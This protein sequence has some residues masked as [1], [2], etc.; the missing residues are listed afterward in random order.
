MPNCV[1]ASDVD[2]WPLARRAAQ[3]VVLPSLDFNVTALSQLIRGGVGGVLFLG[4][5]A[6]PSDLRARISM[7][8][9]GLSRE[10]VPLVMADVEGG[11]VQR[12]QPV[13][14]PF[15]W[16]RDLASSRSGADVEHLAETVGAQMK[17]AGVTVDLGPVVDLDDRPGPSTTNPDGRRSF[18][19]SPAVASGDSIAFMQ[20]LRTA[21]VT[22]VLKHFPGLGGSTHNTDFGPAATLPYAA[23]RASGLQPFINAIRAGAPAIMV[24][25][26]HTPGL[27]TQP[28]SVSPAVIRGL[29]RHQLGFSGLVVTDSLSAGAISAAGFSVTQAA[30][31]AVE[32]G[33][34]MVLFGSTLTAADIAMLSPANVSAT[35]QSIIASL[36][37]AVQKGDMPTQRLNEAVLHVL[38]IKGVAVCPG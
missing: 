24:S 35:E 34:D 37:Q 26:A 25:N 17:S 33:A 22:P 2:R 13:V 32:A 1:S 29:L 5:A 12:L 4:S 27:S 18:S 15:P 9:G 19:I 3:L 8:A 28:A 20:G 36:I 31:A 30:T 16:P 6:A 14:D 11:G 23:L 7:A 38:A 21:N 10:D